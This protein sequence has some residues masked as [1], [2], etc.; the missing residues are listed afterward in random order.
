LETGPLPPNA[1]PLDAVVLV[2]WRDRETG[3]IHWSY[4]DTDE[5]GG[6]RLNHNE[7]WSVFASQ[8]DLFRQAINESWGGADG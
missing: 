6:L 4:R 1:T 2:R 3:L 8:A 5:S 7:L